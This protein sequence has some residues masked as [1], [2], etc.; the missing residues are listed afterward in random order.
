MHILA[1]TVGILIAGLIVF[2]V[3]GNAS[4]EGA[5]QDGEAPGVVNAAGTSLCGK[6]PPAETMTP[7]NQAKVAD[8][9]PTLLDP[10]GKPIGGFRPA[11]QQQWLVRTV[12][13][14]GFCLDEIDLG[15]DGGVTKLSLST[16]A[17]VSPADVAAYTGAA[18]V[19]AHQPPFNNRTV[20]ATTFVGDQ[21][22][23]IK[24]TPRAAGAFATWR[25]TTGSGTSVVD[26]INFSRAVR[27]GAANLQILG[28]T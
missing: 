16:V 19:S 26:I 15:G 27:L 3:F 28:W 1:S 20:L 4:R 14:S 6:V 21:K 24:M 7:A 22:R 2:L 18:L 25:Q 11:N 8:H 5:T 10:T 13:A 9:M 23:S 17:D 12:A